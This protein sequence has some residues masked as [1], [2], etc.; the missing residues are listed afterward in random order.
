VT[1]DNFIQRTGIDGSR[2]ELA[3]EFRANPYGMH[4]AALRSVLNYMRGMPS[5]GKHF[6]LVIR[7][8]EDWALGQMGEPTI[9]DNIRFRSMEEGEWHV[10]RL[11]W[12]KMF[13][14]AIPDELEARP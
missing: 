5:A 6:L 13:G 10:F 2:L 3:A 11:R 4:S 1:A 9:S 7:P 8:G 14:T 12:E